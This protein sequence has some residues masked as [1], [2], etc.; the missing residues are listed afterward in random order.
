MDNTPLTY[1]YTRKG[2]LHRV[3]DTENRLLVADSF[4]VDNGMAR[5]PE[6][7]AARF[8]NSCLFF[9]DLKTSELA[10][11]WQLAMQQIPVGGLWFP[12]VEMAGPKKAPLL[13][14][15]IRPAPQLQ[16]EARLAHGETRD[17]RRHPRHKGPDISLLDKQRQQIMAM[18]ADEGILCTPGQYLLE[19]L[20]SSILWWENGTL[21][22][23]LPSKRVLPSI[24]ATLLREVAIKRHIPFA[25]RF[26]KWQELD[27]C[28]T[29][30]VNALHGIRRAINW[31]LAPWH[32]PAHTDR[33]DWQ[34]ALN[35]HALR[36][37][38]SEYPL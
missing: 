23:T 27:G 17:R 15:R 6:R 13:Q 26:R 38:A 19:G 24:T 32:T 4:L 37:V 28:E 35:Q 18:G 29:W 3:T 2:E 20:F 31:P 25:W 12:R 14:I 21:C 5:A 30:V 33:D 34:L 36:P 22:Q 1:R 16:S 11:F 10:R 9:A 7:H 8:V